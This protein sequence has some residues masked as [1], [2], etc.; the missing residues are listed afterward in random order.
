M[1]DGDTAS[2]A[3]TWLSDGELLAWLQGALGDR[4]RIERELGGG[5]DVARVRRDG[6]G[7]RAPRGHQGAAPGSRWC[8]EHGTVPA[9]RSVS[10]RGSST[11][12]L[13]PC[14]APDEVGAPHDRLLFYTMPF[15]DGESFRAQVTRRRAS[16]TGGNP[17]S[18]VTWPTRSRT[19]TSVAW[20]TVTLS[21]RTCS[22][23]VATRS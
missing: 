15:V 13:F 16:R 12:T 21:Q 19:R 20:C 5:G 7:A 1:Q 8:N 14:S 17:A 3:S 18:C 2:G 9:A 23:R 22:S 4:Y 11:L 10:P 6:T